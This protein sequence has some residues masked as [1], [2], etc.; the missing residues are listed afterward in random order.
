L[1]IVLPRGLVLQGV[2]TSNLPV[3][4]QLLSHLS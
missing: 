1:S 3:V 4:Y 2:T